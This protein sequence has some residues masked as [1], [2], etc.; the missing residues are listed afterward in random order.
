MLSHLSPKFNLEPIVGAHEPRAALFLNRYTRTL[1]IMYA[2]D[3]LADILGIEGD[4]LRGRSFY[5]CIEE[6]CL[7]DAVRCLENAKANDSIAYLRFWYRDPRQDDELERPRAPHTLTTQTSADEVMTDAPDGSD[8]NDTDHMDESP[9]SYQSHREQ[10]HD[11]VES[12]PVSSTDSVEPVSNGRHP[13]P[14][15]LQQEESRTSSGRSSVPYTHEAVFGE[16]AQRYSSA[17]SMS[18]SPFEARPPPRHSQR[19]R[20]R[21]ELE[22][23]VSCTSDGLVVCMRQARPILSDDLQRRTKPMYANGLFAVPWATEPMLPP[24]QQRPIYAQRAAFAPG[25]GPAPARH[26]QPA[27]VARTDRDDFMTAIRE[28]AVFAWALTGINGSLAEYS[29]GQPKGEAQPA[30]GL[31]IWQPEAVQMHTEPPATYS[32]QYKSG[33]GPGDTTQPKTTVNF[34]RPPRPA[35]F[36]SNGF[37]DGDGRLPDGLG[38]SDRSNSLRHESSVSTDRTTPI[39]PPGSRSYEAVPMFDGQG[40]MADSV[41]S[42]QNRKPCVNELASEVRFKGA[43][44]SASALP[45]SNSGNRRSPNDPYGFGDPGLSSK[46]VKVFSNSPL[47]DHQFQTPDQQSNGRNS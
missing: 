40:E 38:G 30:S 34:S 17:S 18:N 31:P 24:P 27:Q 41:D 29:R 6:N 37:L 16:S 35:I 32:A 20:K 42:A 26:A 9:T 21:I 8:Y 4:Q 44:S 46:R 28:I 33:P 19:P 23:V 47:Q 43:W 22:A 13:G 39:S 3:G 14:I 11:T 7:Q 5:Y 25:L 2:T 45:S 12:Q 36:D 10:S 1:T 15:H